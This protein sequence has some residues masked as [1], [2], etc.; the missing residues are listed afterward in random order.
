MVTRLLCH[1]MDGYVRLGPRVFKLQACRLQYTPRASRLVY[2]LPLLFSQ[3]SRYSRLDMCMS[4]ATR[5]HSTS[6][7]K[8]TGTRP[9]HF[10]ENRTRT[11]VT[12]QEGSG[13]GGPIFE[14]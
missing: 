1:L 5:G 11:R 7:K 14:G 6:L 3:R 8:A 12:E 9:P 13:M 4:W 10:T 2:A